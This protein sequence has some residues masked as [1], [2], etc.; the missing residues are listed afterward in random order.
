M[1]VDTLYMRLGL[2][3]GMG[4]SSNLRDEQGWVRVDMG[5]Q[6]GPSAVAEKGNCGVVP[7]KADMYVSI[8]WV[9]TAAVQ[10]SAAPRTRNYVLSPLPAIQLNNSTSQYEVG[11]SYLVVAVIMPCLVSWLVCFLV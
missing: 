6:R 7:W 8:L 1:Y 10:G 9:A 4:G 2:G 3:D 11:S 5:R